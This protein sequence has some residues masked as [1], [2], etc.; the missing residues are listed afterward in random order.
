MAA[1]VTNAAGDQETAV[2]YLVEASNADRYR[3]AALVQQATVGLLSVG[4]IYSAIEFLTAV[5]DEYPERLETR[6]NLFDFL[7]NV[8]EKQRA[9]PH[10][11]ILVRQR[12][13]D[14]V[15]LFSLGTYEQ[16]DMESDSMSLLYQRNPND[17]RLR[18]AEVRSKFDAGEWDGVQEM[19]NKILEHSP[20]NTAAQILLGR[21]FVENG[22]IEQLA[23]WAEL[24]T[25]SIAETWQ[26]WEILGDWSNERGR[27]D[28]AARAYWESTR[29]NLDVG[30]VFAKLATTLAILKGNGH[31]IDD[32]VIDAVTLR[33][34][35]LGRFLHDKDRFYK[36]GNRSNRIAADVSRS[37]MKL[38]RY[39]E[40]E[41]WAAFAMTTPDED[42]DQLVS[43]RN[44]VLAV[45][46]KETPWQATDGFPAVAIDLSDFPAPVPTRLAARAETT[47]DEARFRR[48]V[49][50]VLENQAFARGLIGEPV[51][52]KRT[53]ETT[54]PIYAQM[55]SGGG[56]IDYDQDGW[57]DL[58]VGE[59]GGTPGK[60]DSKT[61]H[62]FRNLDG[63][64]QDTTEPAGVA[65][66]SF[67]QG[68]T[69][70][71]LNE[72]G[73]DDLVLLNNGNNRLF[74]NNGDG[75]FRS[76]DDWFPDD[77]GPAWSTSGAIADF[78]GDGLSDLFVAQYCAGKAPLETA[79][80]D[81]KTNQEV[82]C[83][84]T[85]FAAEPDLFLSGT[86]SGGF[87]NAT[88][89][90]CDPPLQSGRGLG[91]VV[92]ALDSRPGI[93]LFVANDMTNN[94]FWTQ[95]ELDTDND[96]PFRLTESATLHGLAFDSRFRP[97]A[98]MGIATGDLDE[99]GDVDLFVTNLLWNT[100][101]STNK[102]SLQS[103]RTER[104]RKGSC[105]QATTSSASERRRS[106]ST[107][108]LIWNS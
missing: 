108:I 41:A 106:T 49:V 38:G 36:R 85:H 79:C 16:R 102:G 18:L 76:A 24:L 61:N 71:D 13:F 67:A 84:P 15:L 57:P 78:N 40:A 98:C 88:D 96:E 56:A 105:K 17:P 5:V 31:P 45:L 23:G 3:D 12:Q 21:Y 37:L 99:D 101:R 82:S 35:R 27:F 91:V 94:H 107:T 39:W 20:E 68:I 44:E 63:R 87:E 83:S 46:R 90:W 42:I 48:S 77:V 29:R 89:L 75:T 47:P 59:A 66:P 19:L 30:E 34:Q 60:L 7:V 52:K 2:Q 33:A 50:P 9:V 6:R 80:H 26:Y 95:D 25:P 97:Q 11:R 104:C 51:R 4:K 32:D 62:L 53:I 58:Y 65:D 100:T 8:E 55:E 81:S 64:F 43:A 22:Q 73:F 54:I 92:G 14:R 1:E 70:G 86:R 10:G 72:D 103:G 74:I 28:K 69:F 93:D